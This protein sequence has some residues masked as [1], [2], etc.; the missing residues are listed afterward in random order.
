MRCASQSVTAV[1]FYW[2]IS[3][4]HSLTPEDFLCTKLHRVPNVELN[5]GTAFVYTSIPESYMTLHMPK[6]RV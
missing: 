6:H 5:K 1:G 2:P 4:D 3:C